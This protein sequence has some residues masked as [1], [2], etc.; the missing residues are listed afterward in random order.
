MNNILFLF[1][2]IHHEG[3]KHQVHHCGGKH[4]D[5]DPKVDYTISHCVCGKHSIDKEIAI[6]H[7]TNE[8]LEPIEVKVKFTEKCSQGG[9]HIESGIKL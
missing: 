5:I 1:H 3:N 6:G 9:W 8:R 7:A 2:H 4:I